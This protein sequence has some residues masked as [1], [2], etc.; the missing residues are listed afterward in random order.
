[1]DQ[2][3][4]KHVNSNKILFHFDSLV[5][6]HLAVVYALQKDYPSGGLNPRINYSFLHQSRQDLKQFRV[7]GIG[8]NIVQECLNDP[9]RQSY[10]TIYESYINDQFD[11][12]IQHAPLTVMLKIIAAYT[13][14]GRGGLVSPWIYCKDN[15][16][17]K[18]AKGIIKTLPVRFITGD[19]KNINL[20]DYARFVIG[21]VRDLDAFNHPH[22]LHIAVLNY[23][24]N[25]QIVGKQPVIVPDYVIKY[26]DVNIFQIIDSYTD[27]VVPENLK[28][29]T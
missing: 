5:D 19:P 15:R 12:V 1:M 29:E 9:L 3:F 14:V 16:E 25:L 28:K 8:K 27:V 21:D 10:Q 23:G 13:R 18:I 26:G 2:Q 17:L 7:Y 4:K 22:C 20:D 24:S 6:L 11:R